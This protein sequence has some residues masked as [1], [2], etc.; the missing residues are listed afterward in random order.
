MSWDLRS[1]VTDPY[2][3]N[4]YENQNIKLKLKS[5]PTQSVVSKTEAKNYLK[6]SSD[7][8]DDTLVE[9]LITSATGIIERELGGVS[10][11]TQTWLQYQQGGCDVIELMREPVIGTPTVS[12]YSDFETVTATTITATTTFR[13]ID[14]EL[15]HVDGYWER[16]RNGD[17]YTIEF[18][19]GVFTASTVTSS[20]DPRLSVFKTAI[21]RTVAWLYEQREEH[22]TSIREGEWS[23]DYSSE[24]PNGIKRLIMPYHSGRGLI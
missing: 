18:D 17:G 13:N 22:V 9:Q 2:A 12:F 19:T 6:L 10:I 14:N 11:Y 8:T 4:Q 24:L 5:A 16:G 20:Q 1:G 21:L 15:Y 3:D 23:V 7:T